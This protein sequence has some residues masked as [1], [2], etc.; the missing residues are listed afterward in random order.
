MVDE[1]ERRREEIL[2]KI[3]RR[4]ESEVTMYCI[5]WSLTCTQESNITMFYVQQL[6]LILLG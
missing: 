4:I 1:Y 3:C 5:E 6:H 2:V